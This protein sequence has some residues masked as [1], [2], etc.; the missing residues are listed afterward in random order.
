VVVAA[1]V[2]RDV[3]ALVGADVGRSSSRSLQPAARSAHATTIAA[4][5]IAAS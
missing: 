1:A 3:T 4:V 5:R 2:A